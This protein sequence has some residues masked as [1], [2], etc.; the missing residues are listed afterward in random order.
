M[1]SRISGKSDRFKE[2]VVVAF[3]KMWRQTMIKSGYAMIAAS[4]FSVTAVSGVTPA[5]AQPKSPPTVPADRPAPEGSSR[6]SICEIVSRVEAQGY[7]DI[8][9]IER[10]SGNYEV[11][12]KDS[13]GRSVELKVNDQTGKV[14]QVEPMDD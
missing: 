2:P 1:L 10:E 9:E 5:S 12:A 13:Q 11:E 3:G 4:V 8:G 7:R 6:L 14:E